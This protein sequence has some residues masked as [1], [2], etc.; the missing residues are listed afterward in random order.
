MEMLFKRKFQDSCPPADIY[1]E[2]EPDIHDQESAPLIIT[3]ACTPACKNVAATL[4]SKSKDDSNS[5][6]TTMSG[7]RCIEEIIE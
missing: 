6:T 5:S 4:R 1:D 7:K 3:P 2:R